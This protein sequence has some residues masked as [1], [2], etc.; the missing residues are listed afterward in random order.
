[1]EENF[2]FKKIGQECSKTLYMF[3]NQQNSKIGQ[4]CSILFN[5][6]KPNIAGKVD[7]GDIEI[8]GFGGWCHCLMW[9]LWKECNGRSFE[10][11]E[12]TSV[13]KTIVF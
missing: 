8:W 1:M 12:R 4:G 13:K 2:V 6:L 9:C 11:S 5:M 10:D 3:S 7:L